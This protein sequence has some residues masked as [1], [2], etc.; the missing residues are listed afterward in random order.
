MRTADSNVSLTPIEIE[1]LLA[2]L[3]YYEQKFRVERPEKMADDIRVLRGKLL[4]A[5]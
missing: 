3:A 4:D 2:S 5:D 1:L